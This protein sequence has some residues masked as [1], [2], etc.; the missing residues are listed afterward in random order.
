MNFDG[1]TKSILTDNCKIHTFRSGGGLRV[2][3]VS[4]PK[5]EKGYGEHPDLMEAFRHAN[6]DYLAGGRPYKEGYGKLYDHYLT[7]STGSS[8]AMDQFVK[9]GYN[10]DLEK[11]A[12]KK[13][14]LTANWSEHIEMPEHLKNIVMKE[15]LTV[16]WE[17][18]GRTFESY[19]VKF[20]NGEIGY[21]TKYV[22]VEKLENHRMYDREVSISVS[23]ETVDEAFREAEK[24]LRAKY[25]AKYRVEY[26]ISEF[27]GF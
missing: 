18:D 16:V 15:G 25:C 24:Q 13:V 17:S 19:P 3:G 27:F 5:K 12:D 8:S 23:A 2:V 21:G 11:S 6:E 22:G 4:T 1:L 9:A 14:L 10:I 26:P 7:G 20:A